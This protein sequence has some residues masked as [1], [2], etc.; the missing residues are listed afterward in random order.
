MG[1][2]RHRGV[3]TDVRDSERG[4][5]V[6]LIFAAHPLARCS[7]TFPQMGRYVAASRAATTTRIAAHS[8]VQIWHRASSLAFRCH[9]V[10]EWTFRSEMVSA[11][12]TALD[13]HFLQLLRFLIL[14]RRLLLLLSALKPHHRPENDVLAQSGSI[15]SRTRRLACLRA[16]LGPCSPFSHSW[17][18]LF[19][20]NRPSDALCSFDALAIFVNDDCHDCLRAIFVFGDLRRWEGRC[21]IR[22]TVF[23]PICPPRWILHCCCHVWFCKFCLG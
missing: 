4:Q 5:I 12:D 21:Q 1:I 7:T 17:I 6:A 11:A 14:F 15:W 19:L 16:H 2:V 20:D 23:C 8:L 18:F 22:L 9:R 3:M 10:L 13:L